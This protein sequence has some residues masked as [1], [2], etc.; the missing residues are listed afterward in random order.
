MTKQEVLFRLGYSVRDLMLT[1]ANE[2]LGHRYPVVFVLDGGHRCLTARTRPKPAVP[3]LWR[4][5]S[6][7]F[8]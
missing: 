2:E 3:F 4:I 8:V 7:M 5:R 1:P 6:S